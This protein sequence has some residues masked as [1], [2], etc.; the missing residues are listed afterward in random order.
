MEVSTKTHLYFLLQQN[1]PRQPVV[2]KVLF[3]DTRLFVSFWNWVSKRWYWKCIHTKQEW[4]QQCTWLKIEKKQETEK[5]RAPSFFLK[6]EGDHFKDF[7][8]T[9]AV[10]IIDAL[11]WSNWPSSYKTAVESNFFEFARF[12]AWSIQTCCDKSFPNLWKNSHYTLYSWT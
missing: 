2:F 7:S 9:L 6:Q 11:I 8:L 4:H 3:D 12:W 1:F 5:E 10:Y